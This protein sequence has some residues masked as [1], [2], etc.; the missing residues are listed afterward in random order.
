MYSALFF[1][2]LLTFSESYQKGFAEAGVYNR[3]L[4]P[5]RQANKKTTELIQSAGAGQR[6]P[7]KPAQ[8]TLV[9][10]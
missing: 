7:I 1:E 6:G 2:N 5:S 10:G 3:Q 4:F 9:N 8:K